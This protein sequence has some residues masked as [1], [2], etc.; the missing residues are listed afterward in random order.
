MIIENRDGL[1]ILYS[2]D[3]N[4]ITDKNRTFYSNILYLGVNDNISNYEEVP[5]DIWINYL[6]DTGKDYGIIK[7][8]VDSIESNQ[9][10]LEEC[11]IST[12]Y[13]LLLLQN[14]LEYGEWSLK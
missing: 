10:A 1:T 12:D 11:L 2:E 6:E 5:R 7:L 4:K 3:T 13:Q 9:I 14:K 8:M